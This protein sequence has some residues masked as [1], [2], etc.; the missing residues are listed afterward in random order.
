MALVAIAAIVPVR[1][2]PAE[3][4]CHASSEFDVQVDGIYQPDA[5]VFVLETPGELLI[6]IPS[7]ANELLVELGTKKVVAI[8]R[9]NIKPGATNDDIRVVVPE[10]SKTSSY[11]MTIDGQNL[12]LRSENSEVVITKV[13]KRPPPAAP[14][15]AGTPFNPS[16]EARAC[17]RW[18]SLPAPVGTPGCGKFVYLRNSCDVP[19]VA[20]VS[21]TEHLMTGTLPQTFQVVVPA[22]GEQSI[23]CDW[24]SGAMAPS[25]H[26]LLDAGFLPE[27]GRR[28]AHGGKDHASGH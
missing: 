26:A 2:T 15:G 24:W 20:N 10:T 16:V 27:A 22:Q 28:H 14:A 25:E 12:H 6:D 21:R 8:S 13:G 19:V 17:L 1:A 11:E 23:G 7:L 4:V 5:R 9:W 3:L 18:E